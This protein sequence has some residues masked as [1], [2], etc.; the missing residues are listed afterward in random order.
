MA[1]RKIHKGFMLMIVF[2]LFSL[3]FILVIPNLINEGY[4]PYVNI[5]Y[6]APMLLFTLVAVFLISVFRL[7]G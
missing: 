6:I 1:R 4:L 3:I 7:Y 5:T 2:S